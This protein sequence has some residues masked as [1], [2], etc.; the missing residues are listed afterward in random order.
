ME[1]GVT[2][3]EN[4]RWYIGV[5]T[6]FQPV[7]RN[8]LSLPQAVLP[9]LND[10]II[11]LLLFLLIMIYYVYSLPLLTVN[12]SVEL[13][14]GLGY[15][16]GVIFFNALYKIRRGVQVWAER[17][18]TEH[19]VIHLRVGVIWNMMLFFLYI[20]YFLCIFP[21]C[22]NTFSAM[23]TRLLFGFRELLRSYT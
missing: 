12:L 14:V 16:E 17:W 4:T 11:A 10:L 3:W 15:F 5:K 19:A 2:L 1:E 13:Q 7:W 20:P 6:N 18:V 9:L 21:H 23:N 22:W 8:S